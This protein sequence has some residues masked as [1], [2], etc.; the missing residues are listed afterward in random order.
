M[1]LKV[2][3]FSDLHASDRTAE[4][5]RHSL[6]FC[7]DHI[8]S[9]RCDLAVFSG[10]LWHGPIGIA[11]ASPVHWVMGELH[12]LNC[13]L[14]MVYGTASHDNR[15]SLKV[16]PWLQNYSIRISDTPETTL[17]YG[18]AR[19]D[20]FARTFATIEDYT[21]PGK[22]GGPPDA[23]IFTLPA[24]TKANLLANV[25]NLA[26]L[27]IEETNQIIT[28]ELRKI[29]LGF[30][31]IGQEFDCPKILVGHI[32]VAGSELS[33][34]QTM[35]GGDIQVGKADLELAGVDY[36]ALG[37]IHKPQAVSEKVHYAGS[38]HPL[39]WGEAEQKSFNIVAFQDGRLDVG[40]IPLPAPPMVD[41]QASYN[42]ET[43][44]YDF[45]AQET[46]GAEVRFRVQYSQDEDWVI[47]EKQIEEM[48]PAALSVK[49]EKL[50]VPQERVRS[51][52][53]SKAVTLRDKVGAFCEAS[54][55]EPSAG[56]LAKADT[57]EIAES[58]GE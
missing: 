29:F 50:P 11:E 37:H 47:S 39:N 17:F 43:G 18:P 14:V 13:P 31:A 45:V 44:G 34:G 57:L 42:P 8:N 20:R 26:G 51:K 25:P 49:V 23:I 27:G 54:G 1:T 16:L 58:R 53:I 56:V 40:R 19:K 55:E 46:K 15:G 33:T 21:E 35:P 48:F 3:H 38:M 7:V 9:D 30:A 10:D 2:A 41:I 6:K 5:A 52:E 22:V 4:K 36:Y 12:R 28:E 24:P 32:T